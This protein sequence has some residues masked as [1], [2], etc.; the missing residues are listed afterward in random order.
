MF[1]YTLE[2]IFSAQARQG[3]LER[4]V[5]GH[6]VT[7]LRPAISI[8]INSPCQ[9]ADKPAWGCICS[10]ITSKIT[11]RS[12][13][14]SSHRCLGKCSVIRASSRRSWVVSRRRSRR[15]LDDQKAATVNG[16]NQEALL[17]RPGKGGRDLWILRSAAASERPMMVIGIK[18]AHGTHT[19]LH[20]TNI[21]RAR[22][23]KCP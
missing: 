13:F 20:R 23:H 12:L 15:D 5:C 2:R 7:S 6:D 22:A 4:R 21:K 3:S 8:D 17:R 10:P 18:L 16:K 9:F 19:S 14:F 11:T 1:L